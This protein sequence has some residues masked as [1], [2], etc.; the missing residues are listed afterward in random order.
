MPAIAAKELVIIPAALREPK[1]MAGEET[2][3]GML[4]LS[5]PRLRLQK[6]VPAVARVLVESIS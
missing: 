3:Q 5:P 2:D 4:H 1:K 6:R